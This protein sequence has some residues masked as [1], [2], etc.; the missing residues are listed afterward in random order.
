LDAL[1]PEHLRTYLNHLP[2]ITDDS[3]HWESQR[4]RRCGMGMS[5]LL[6]PFVAPQLS[7]PET[8]H[9]RVE[10]EQDGA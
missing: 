7:K 10:E 6:S 4:N 3:R 1:V 9:N 8:Q 2:G 5:A